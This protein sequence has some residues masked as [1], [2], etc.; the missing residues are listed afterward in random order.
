MGTFITDEYFFTGDGYKED[1][2]LQ[3]SSEEFIG[4]INRLY[5]NKFIHPSTAVLYIS[6]NSYLPS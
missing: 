4:F 3:M 5:N 6:F 2:S 1:F